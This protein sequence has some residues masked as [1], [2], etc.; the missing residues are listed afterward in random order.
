[1]K[2]WIITH[3][4]ILEDE[5]IA[6]ERQVYLP[7]DKNL[8]DEVLSEAYKSYLAVYLGRIKMYRDLKEFYWQP[9]INKGIAEYMVKCKVCQQVKVE[10]QKLAR[11]FQPLLIPEWK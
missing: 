4:Q 8:K 9:N 10:Y 1:M 5:M 3:F 2:E 7:D 6:M 11:Q